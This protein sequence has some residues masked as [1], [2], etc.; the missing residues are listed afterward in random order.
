M[1]FYCYICWGILNTVFFWCDSKVFYSL[2][3]F[4]SLFW[5]QSPSNDIT[6]NLIFPGHLYISYLHTLLSYSDLPSACYHCP[7]LSNTCHHLHQIHIQSSWFISPS[8]RFV[9]ESKPH[10][11]PVIH[12]FVFVSLSYFSCLLC[13]HTF[14][15]FMFLSASCRLSL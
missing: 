10:V 4:I 14:S 5:K 1:I 2:I 15:T 8:I 12:I 13:F 6:N 9:N 11:L 7:S 3:K